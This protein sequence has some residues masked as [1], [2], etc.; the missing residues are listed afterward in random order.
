MHYFVLSFN[1]D[2]DFDLHPEMK[3]DYYFKEYSFATIKKVID[4]AREITPHST[5]ENQAKYWQKLCS[6]FLSKLRKSDV[7]DYF[8]TGVLVGGNQTISLKMMYLPEEWDD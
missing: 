7:K 2:D 5:K 1:T 6:E 4:K 3:W 8:F